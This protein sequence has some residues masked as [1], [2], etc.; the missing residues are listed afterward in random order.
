MIVL[1]EPGRKHLSTLRES[2]QAWLIDHKIKVSSAE[3][4]QSSV[5]EPKLFLA[6]PAPASEA[7][8]S[9]ADSGSGSRQIGS[10]L[11]LAQDKK[12]RLRLILSSKKVNYK[13]KS[14]L[15]HI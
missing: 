9:G 2:T 8:S 15:V 10:A 6:A 11:T 3:C 13:L 1:Q 7:R 5:A 14:F 4:L 12:V